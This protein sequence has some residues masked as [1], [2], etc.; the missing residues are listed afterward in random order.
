MV[1]VLVEKYLSSVLELKFCEW[2]VLPS[3]Q[4]SK[5]PRAHAHGL[6]QIL[7]K[8]YECSLW[9]SIKFHMTGTLEPFA[10]SERS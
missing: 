4:S 5:R 1:L 10:R 8:N 3:N 6:N 2:K 9:S 7:A